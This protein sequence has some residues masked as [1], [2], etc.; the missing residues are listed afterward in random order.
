MEWNSW[1]M[2]YGEEEEQTACVDTNYYCQEYC[3]DWYTGEPNDL[4]DCND[5]CADDY[6]ECLDDA[7]VTAPPPVVDP[8]VVASESS[9]EE[10][11]V[12]DPVDDDEEED[13]EVVLGD[14]NDDGGYGSFEYCYEVYDDV[15]EASGTYCVEEEYFE[16]CYES[17]DEVTETEEEYCIAELYTEEC[18]EEFYDDVEEV[19]V[20]DC[21]WYL[22]YDAYNYADGCYEVYDVCYD[23]CYDDYDAT[24]ECFYTCSTNYWTCYHDEDC[25]DEFLDC[26]DDC[27]NDVSCI[28]DCEG[29]EEYCYGEYG[30]EID[31]L[32]TDQSGECVERC[33]YPAT[34]DQV[35]QECYC[36]TGEH[37]DVDGDCIESGCADGEYWYGDHT[38]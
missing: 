16:H 32:P 8:V 11:V 24:W 19:Y 30:V 21:Y 38:G 6:E 10:V 34:W 28:A 33:T 5:D 2:T 22:Y 9:E 25:N 4:D 20:E 31:Y 37:F 1:G 13:E 23:Y 3:T 14:L 29:T 7:G 18:E 36:P 26:S 35:D 15:I 12:V 17:Y 27:A